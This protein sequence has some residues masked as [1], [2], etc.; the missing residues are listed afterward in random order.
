MKIARS[1]IDGIKLEDKRL[2]DLLFQISLKFSLGAE[3]K[4]PEMIIGEFNELLHRLKEEY[5]KE[6]KKNWPEK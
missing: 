1:L 6:K 4:E 5:F 3:N 2:A